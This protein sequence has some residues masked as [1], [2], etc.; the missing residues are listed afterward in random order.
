MAF[1]DT[2]LTH[3]A[4]LARLEL[5]EEERAPLRADLSRLLAYLAQLQDVDVEGVAAMHRPLDE[6]PCGDAA[7]HLPGT[8][9]DVVDERRALGPDALDA[10]APAMQGG[11]VRVART[12]DESG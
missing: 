4:T 9:A 1:D 7:G 3:L 8:R 5:G 6:A 2:N 11:R 10:L 12:V